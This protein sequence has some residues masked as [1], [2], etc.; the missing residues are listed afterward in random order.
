MLNCVAAYDASAY[1]HLCTLD[2]DQKRA[3]VPEV[4]IMTKEELQMEDFPIPT[5]L[6]PNSVL[7]DDWVDTLPGAGLTPKRLVALDCEMVSR[8]GRFEDRETK[9]H[10]SVK[11]S[12]AMQ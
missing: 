11:Q 9:P 7:E 12:M 8:Y 6:D 10:D 3:I 1:M 5:S 2:P 4:L